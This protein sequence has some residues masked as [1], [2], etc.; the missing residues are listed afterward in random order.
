MKLGN[1]LITAC[2]G[3]AVAAA[4]GMAI[5]VHQQSTANTTLWTTVVC[6]AIGFVFGMI[7]KFEIW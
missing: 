3:L 1:R 6:G 2:I 4:V 7:F 5:C